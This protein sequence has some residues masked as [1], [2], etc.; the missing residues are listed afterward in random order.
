MF[1]KLNRSVRQSFNRFSTSTNKK[2]RFKACCRAD[3]DLEELGKVFGNCLDTG[4]VL[5]LKGD[6]CFT[7]FDKSF[8]IASCVS[9][10]K[11]VIWV[12]VRRLFHVGLFVRNSMILT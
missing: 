4:D 10:Y 2:H 6:L 11:Q 7:S 9:F 5:L 12:L 1:V 3:F 8:L